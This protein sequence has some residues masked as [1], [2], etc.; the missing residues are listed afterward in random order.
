MRKASTILAIGLVALF[1]SYSMVLSQEIPA[2]VTKKA[3]EHKV[4]V[5]FAQALIQVESNYNPKV[6]GQKGEYGL[7]Q[8]LCST[9]KS[10]G[11]NQQCDQLLDPEINLEYSM[12]L[13]RWSLDMSKDDIC[14]AANLYSSG[15]PNIYRKTRYCREVM[16]RM[17]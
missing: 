16:K 14:G 10:V 1:S 9:A 11:F 3:T 4:P 8:I 5:A 7:G 2:I 13:I 17:V 15:V 12:R 6:R